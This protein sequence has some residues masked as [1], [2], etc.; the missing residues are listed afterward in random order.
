MSCAE[1]QHPETTLASHRVRKV[2]LRSAVQIEIVLIAP[3]DRGVNHR[4][5][6]AWNP[7]GVM[8][9]RRIFQPLAKQRVILSRFLPSPGHKF[10]PA[11]AKK[12]RLRVQVRICCAWPFV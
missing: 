9:E 11:D 6:K 4:L 8:A 10:G 1:T 12:K 7:P 3:A 2:R 5:V